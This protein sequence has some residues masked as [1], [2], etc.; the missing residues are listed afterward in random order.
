M[1]RTRRDLLGAAGALGGAAW[2]SSM[3]GCE[4]RGGPAAPAGRGGIAPSPEEEYVWLS[5]NAHL[6]LFVAHDHPALFQV[7]RELGVR[8]TIAGPDTID[9]PSLIAAIEQTTARRPTGMIVV[10]W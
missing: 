7:G 1:K 2:L 6:P 3:A 4:D 5:A 10:G 8:V 9:I